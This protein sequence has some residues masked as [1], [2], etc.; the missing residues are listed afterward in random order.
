MAKRRI[1]LIVNLPTTEEGQAELARR[2]TEFNTKLLA[3]AL[4]KVD[5]PVEAKLRYLE[6]LN[7]VVPWAARK[8]EA[9]A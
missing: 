3:Y 4:N 9:H 6:S 2:V 1:N 7:G 8:E 5:V